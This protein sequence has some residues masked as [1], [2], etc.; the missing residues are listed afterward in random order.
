MYYPIENHLE[1]IKNGIIVFHSPKH[2]GDDVDREIRAQII[3]MC[4][5]YQRFQL[6]LLDYQ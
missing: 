4:N 6:K 5:L 2:S 3:E 1:D